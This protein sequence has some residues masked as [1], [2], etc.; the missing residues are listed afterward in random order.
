MSAASGTGGGGG[1]G[2]AAGTAA[3]AAAAADTKIFPRWRIHFLSLAV[4]ECCFGLFCSMPAVLGPAARGPET[5]E[6]SEI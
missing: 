2:A 5:G 1:G 4:A 6:K 3:A